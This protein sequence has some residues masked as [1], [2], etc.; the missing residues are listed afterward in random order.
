LRVPI[1][2]AFTLNR[3]GPEGAP[4]PLSVELRAAPDGIQELSLVALRFV[5]LVDALVARAGPRFVVHGLEQTSHVI[6]GEPRSASLSEI[7]A[8]NEVEASVLDPDSLVVASADL[9]AL[10]GDVAHHQ[11]FAFDWE[12]LA[13]VEEIVACLTREEAPPEPW[14]RLTRLPRSTTWLQVHDDCYVELE[15]R[16]PALAR[17]VVARAL[18]LWVGTALWSAGGGQPDVARP[19]GAILDA[20]LAGGAFTLPPEATVV[21]G[22]RVAMGF[23]RRAWSPREERAEETP[24]EQLLYDAATRRWALG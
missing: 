5:D 1:P 22:E 17:A 7:A 24:A 18:Q 16:R 13:E 23:L 20:L 4:F 8:E 15:T 3:L 10:L 12:G 6:D 19:P 2:N 21:E 11:L 9:R 14:V